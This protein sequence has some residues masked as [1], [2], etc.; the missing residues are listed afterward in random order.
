MLLA[1]DT[2]GPFCSA[3]FHHSGNGETLIARSD[4]IGRG[5]AE[6]L[7]PM[8]ADLM[9]HSNICWQDV[10]KVGCVT[11]PG[12][13]TGLRVGLATARGLA[14][15]IGCSCVGITLFDA[16]VEQFGDGQP[17]CVA[18]DAKRNQIWMQVFDDSKTPLTSASAIDGESWSLPHNVVRVAGSAASMLATQDPRL[19]VVSDT[20]CPPIEAVGRLAM[21]ANPAT[22][23]AHAFYLRLPDAKPQKTGVVFA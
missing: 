11:G 17:L 12:S 20:H 1:L 8:L 21:S 7:M 13:F 19:S 2:S 9:E 18:A 10:T 14:L 23:V 22:D 3:S 16:Y 15:A 4:N 6:H 5:H